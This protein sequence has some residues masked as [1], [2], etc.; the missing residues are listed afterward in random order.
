VPIGKLFRCAGVRTRINTR[1]DGPSTFG[2]LTT[3]SVSLH[4]GDGIEDGVRV[5]AAR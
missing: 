4:P 5:T 1:E 2:I 3:T